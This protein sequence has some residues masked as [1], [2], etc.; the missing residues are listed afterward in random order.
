MDTNDLESLVVR[1]NKLKAFRDRCITMTDGKFC[2]NYVDRSAPR[3]DLRTLSID[4]CDTSIILPDVRKIIEG[5]IHEVERQIKI[6]A[7]G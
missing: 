6:V 7:N 3:T 4:E 2:I 1:C 5:R